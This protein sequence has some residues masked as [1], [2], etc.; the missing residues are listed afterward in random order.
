M[1]IPLQE[2]LFPVHREVHPRC[3]SSYSESFGL[4]MEVVCS[5]ETS[6]LTI[7]TPH[8][9]IQKIAHTFIHI[10]LEMFCFGFIGGSANIG[11]VF[12]IPL[13]STKYIRSDR[14]S[15]PPDSLSGTERGEYEHFT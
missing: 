15:K 1:E 2:V 12:H 11:L 5:S 4:K 3:K 13:H 9:H 7:T 8:R 14:C 10:F 6:V